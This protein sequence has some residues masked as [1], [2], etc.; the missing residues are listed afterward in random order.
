[1]KELREVLAEEERNSAREEQSGVP[2]TKAQAEQQTEHPCAQV[3]GGHVRGDQ[4]AESGKAKEQ[5]AQKGRRQ[6]ERGRAKEESKRP[7]E[8]SRAEKH[9]GNRRSDWELEARLQEQLRRRR[10]RGDHEG[11][12]RNAQEWVQQ[13]KKRTKKKEQEGHGMGSLRRHCQRDSATWA[14]RRGTNHRH[15]HLHRRY[16]YH[17]YYLWHLQS[18][19]CSYQPSPSS[20]NR[21][22]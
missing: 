22:S 6:A 20:S 8:V 4:W 3:A 13:E 14:H 5:P 16:C 18:L 15:R 9:A 10:Q 1:M 21:P 2:R 12:R 19:A 11:S 7:Q 17:C